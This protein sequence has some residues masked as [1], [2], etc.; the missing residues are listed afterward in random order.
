MNEA[1]KGT[2]SNKI[3]LWIVYRELLPTE[4]LA[5]RC[6]PSNTPQMVKGLGLEVS[7]EI[8]SAE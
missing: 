7:V 8:N 5:E 4:L 1:E 6:K 3:E 2:S